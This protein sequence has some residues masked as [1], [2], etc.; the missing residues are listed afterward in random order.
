MRRALTISL[1]SWLVLSSLLVWSELDTMVLSIV[2]FLVCW[3]FAYHLAE[4]V[5]QVRSVG[6]V[7]VHYTPRKVL[8]RGILAGIVIACSVVMSNVGSAVSGIFSV[9]P[10]MF[11]SAMIISLREHGPEFVEGLSKAMIFGTPSVMSYAI[12][13]HMFYPEIG[14]LW[15][16]LASTVMAVSMGMGMLSLRTRIQ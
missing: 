7:K 1:S 12:G 2:V 5:K 14:I 13:V 9:F 3:L 6:K 4:R 11:L 15:G 8:G 16:T 10:A